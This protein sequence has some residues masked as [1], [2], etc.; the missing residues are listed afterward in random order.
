[1]RDNNT[2]NNNKYIEELEDKIT[3]LA[4]KL[5]HK[6]R[7]FDNFKTFNN[8]FVSKLIHN[9]KNPI[10][11]IYSFSEM[12]LSGLENYTPEKLAK[13]LGVV[14]NS[15]DFVI[16]FMNS[17]GIYFLLHSNELILNI[18]RINLNNFIL[19]IG[20]SFK[21]EIDSKKGNLQL[22]LPSETIFCEVDEEYLAMALKNLVSNAIRYSNETVA[23]SIEITSKEKTVEISINDR[24]IG[25]SPTDLT[26]IF[27]E[28]YVVNTY[29]SDSEKCIGLGLPIAK[30][31]IELHNGNISVAS[32]FKN[33][34]AFIITLSAIF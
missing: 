3:S 7:E 31:I 14:K 21:N 24:G 32:D 17:L 16:K 22:K 6:T 23:V 4:I 11:V 20:E 29:S 26:E 15:S 13:H 30:K 5:N 10:G 28:F 1:M 18:K 27:K 34:T 33:G 25:I 8:N 9:V 19:K 12:M 2:K